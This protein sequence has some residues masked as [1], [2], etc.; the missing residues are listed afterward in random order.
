MGHGGSRL[1]ERIYGHLGT[2]RHRSAEVEYRIENHEETL[3]DR[4][5]ALRRPMKLVV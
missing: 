1:V 3:A 5:E 2:I 4:L